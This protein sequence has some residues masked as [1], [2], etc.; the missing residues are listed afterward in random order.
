MVCLKIG[1]QW[2]SAKHKNQ[3]D[4]HNL[5]GINCKDPASGMQKMSHSD[6]ENQNAAFQ[7]PGQG[8]GP[9]PEELQILLMNRLTF[10]RHVV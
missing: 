4:R 5:V 8:V 10:H 6:I 7:T 1:A 2:T 9:V 3:S